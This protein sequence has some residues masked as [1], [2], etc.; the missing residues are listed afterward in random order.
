MESAVR[1]STSD[2]C[3][4]YLYKLKRAKIEKGELEGITF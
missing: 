4:A 3:N 2:I 1:Q